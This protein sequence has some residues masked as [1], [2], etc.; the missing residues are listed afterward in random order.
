M[1]TAPLR[2]PSRASVRLAARVP[3]ALAM[4]V[5]AYAQAHGLA[6]STLVRAG[7]AWVLTQ[8]PPP[9]SRRMPARPEGQAHQQRQLPTRISRVL[10]AHP[11]GIDVAMITAQL[12]A[13]KTP[14]HRTWVQ[15]TQVG[16]CLRHMVLRGDVTRLARGVYAP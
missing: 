4:Q 12:N 8:P 7:L 3:Q 14:K 5:Q 6:L 9:G 16:S 10:T 15:R 11:A 1:T 13:G 2:A